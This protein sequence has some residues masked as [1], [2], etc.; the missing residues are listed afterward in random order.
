MLRIYGRDLCEG[1]MKTT[2]WLR[3][4]GLYV[5][6]PFEVFSVIR[7]EPRLFISF[8]VLDP[9]HFVFVYLMRLFNLFLSSL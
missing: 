9:F 1:E 2:S 4:C 7:S 6:E 3:L 8:L 5:T